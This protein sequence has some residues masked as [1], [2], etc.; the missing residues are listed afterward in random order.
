MEFLFPSESSNADG[1][2]IDWNSIWL[3]SWDSC[4]LDFAHVSVLMASIARLQTHSSSSAVST[5]LD[6]LFGRESI[7]NSNV[8]SYNQSI[9]GSRSSGE[10]VSWQFR[11]E[12]CDLLALYILYNSAHEFLSQKY[13]NRKSSIATSKD[14]P[15][16]T[17]HQAAIQSRQI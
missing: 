6:F 7:W 13:I 1:V 17:S 11:H 2:T 14:H 4:N 12:L 9:K 5:K 15:R 16:P 10:D 3:L 8:T